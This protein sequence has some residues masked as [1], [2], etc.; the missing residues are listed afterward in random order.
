[1]LKN[2]GMV[3]GLLDEVVQ[4]R[5]DLCAKALRKNCCPGIRQPAV[6]VHYALTKII[7]EAVGSRFAP[8]DRVLAAPRAATFLSERWALLLGCLGGVLQQ[9]SDSEVPPGGG[10]RSFF[11]LAR[12]LF[13]VVE[14][15]YPSTSHASRCG[16]S[17]FGASCPCMEALSTRTTICILGREQLF[18]PNC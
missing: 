6:H 7:K 17:C 15:L 9:T 3:Q 2:L 12:F 8:C 1:M 18:G 13:D 10:S 4:Q 16:G 11:L 14:A 5:T